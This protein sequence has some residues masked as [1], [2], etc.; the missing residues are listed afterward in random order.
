MLTALQF[1]YWAVLVYLPLFLSTG[2]H[3]SMERTGT[4]LLAATLPMLLVPLIGGRLAT[5]W[6]WRC[7]FA[8]AFGLIALGDVS[9]LVAAPSGSP[10]MRLAATAAGM[11]AIGIGA[12]LTNPQLAGVALAFAPATQAGMTSA[13]TMIVRQAG[14]A[15]SIA[16]LG[17]TLDTVNAAAT[18]AQAF[19]LAALVALLGMSAAL[20]LIPATA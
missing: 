12:A 3:M 19:A 5:H 10:G 16:A 2:L 14:F 18:F 17:V 11:I 9:L 4:V 1:G 6:G 8:M 13:V 20:L 15:V 7:L